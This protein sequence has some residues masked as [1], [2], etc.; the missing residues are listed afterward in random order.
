MCDVFPNESELNNV[1]TSSKW[2]CY[3]IKM[4]VI[5]NRQDQSLSI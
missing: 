4:G 5:S 3:H 2:D 1:M